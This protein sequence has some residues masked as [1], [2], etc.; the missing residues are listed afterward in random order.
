MNS[1][2][3]NVLNCLAKQ[4]IENVQG[5]DGPKKVSLLFSA[6]TLSTASQFS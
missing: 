5:E 2:K 4:W 1:I 3:R 6:I